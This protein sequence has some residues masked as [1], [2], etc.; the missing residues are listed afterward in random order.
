MS[1][2]DTKTEILEEKVEVNET[3]DL[4]AEKEAKKAKVVKIAKKVGKIACVAGVGFLGYLLGA[5]T[6]N[7]NNDYDSDIMDVDYETENSD[8]Q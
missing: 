5:K 1:E 6:A 3:T 8:E 2:K 4:V 7:K